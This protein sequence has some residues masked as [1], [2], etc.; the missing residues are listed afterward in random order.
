ML[1]L[2]SPVRWSSTGDILL[3]WDTLETSLQLLHLVGS[4]CL[5]APNQNFGGVQATVAGWGSTQAG[6]RQS[7]VLR[8]VDVQVLCD[9]LNHKISI[10]VFD[11][12]MNFTLTF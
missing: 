7:D 2:A 11:K 6:T 8:K 9:F 12:H 3:L 10:Y 1:Y 5:P 4:I